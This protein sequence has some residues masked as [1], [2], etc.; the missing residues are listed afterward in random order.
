METAIIQQKIHTIR[1]QKIMLDA[2]LASLYGVETKR[3]KEAV[4]RNLERFPA[5]FMFELTTQEYFS[6]RTQFASLEKTGKGKHSKYPPYAFTEQGIAM[7]SGVLSSPRAIDMNI[8]IMRAFISV[9]KI[10][11]QCA[12]LTEEVQKIQQT[13]ENHNEQLV[14]IYDAI[15]NILD[16]QVEQKRMTNRERIGFIK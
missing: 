3:L 6:L 9:R 8:A 14:L 13:V 2:D 12:A 15:E 5:D 10:S 1:D 16:E 11:M 7:L 4:R